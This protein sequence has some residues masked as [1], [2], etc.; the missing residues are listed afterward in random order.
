MEPERWQFEGVRSIER[1]V[2]HLARARQC[3]FDARKAAGFAG[4]KAAEHVLDERAATLGDFARN[5]ESIKSHMEA[6]HVPG[7]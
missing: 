5:L 3:L 1:A 7:R 6:S 4:L 2:D